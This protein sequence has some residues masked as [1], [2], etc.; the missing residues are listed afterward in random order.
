ME[1]RN[2]Y[3]GCIYRDES[4]LVLTSSE[5]DNDGSHTD[6]IGKK[7][8]GSYNYYVCEEGSTS[9]CSNTVTVIF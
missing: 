1:R 8:G 3:Q 2:G 4:T 6:N 9:Q 5:S 7:G